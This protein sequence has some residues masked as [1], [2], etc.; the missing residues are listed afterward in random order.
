MTDCD[1]ADTLWWMADKGKPGRRV[2]TPYEFQEALKLRL[3]RGRKAQKLGLAAMA[4][5]LTKPIGREISADTYRKWES[6][7][8]IPHDAI[9]PACDLIHMHVFA[10][11]GALTEEERK[12]I[13]KADRRKMSSLQPAALES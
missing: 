11:L 2:G 12:T 4:T 8:L 10:F 13:K 5:Q 9:L 1:D 3:H 7:S 6:E